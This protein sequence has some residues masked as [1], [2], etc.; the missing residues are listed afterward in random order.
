MACKIILFLSE[1]KESAKE[2]K[3]RCPV[4]DDVIGAQTNEAPVHY[5]LRQ[6]SNVNEIICIVTERAREKGWE[7]FQNKIREENV[8]VAWKKCGLE[9][10]SCLK[11]PEVFATR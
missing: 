2:R 8:D 10:R 3:Y 6:Y 5:L 9:M 4:G 11:R 7:V 1:Y